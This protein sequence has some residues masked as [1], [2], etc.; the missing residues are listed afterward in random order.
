MTLIPDTKDWAWVLERPCPECGYDGRTVQ[1]GALPHLITENAAAWRSVLARPDLRERPNP[2]TWSALEYAAHVRDVFGVFTLRLGLM[3][4]QDNPEFPNWDQDAT[5][6]AEHY[7]EQ[8]PQAVATELAAAAARAAD[9]FAAV[10]D[11]DTERRGRRSDGA[12]FTVASLGRYF[13]HDPVHHLH[14]VG[15]R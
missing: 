8:D 13:V 2:A 3:L 12:V 14:D 10:P 11:G 15:G 7:N 1:F 6:E 4:T 5:A 9:A